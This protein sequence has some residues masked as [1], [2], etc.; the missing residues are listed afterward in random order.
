[1]HTHTHTH[2]HKHTH[3]YIRKCIHSYVRSEIHSCI[4][5]RLYIDAC[6]HICIYLHTHMHSIIHTQWIQTRC[7]L[8]YTIWHNNSSY[9]IDM[10]VCVCVCVSGSLMLR[11]HKNCISVHLNNFCPVNAFPNFF[12]EFLFLIYVFSHH[13]VSCVSANV[14]FFVCVYMCALIKLY[15]HQ[16]RKRA[17]GRKEWDEKE[18]F[19][20]D[21]ES[22][23]K[24][25]NTPS[26]KTA[27]RSQY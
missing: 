7:L 26:K 13:C 19:Q 12:C 9:S 24:G 4:H 1:M 22:R 14:H 21:T 16:C 20:P 27:H 2:T 5:T 15:C 3:K 10:C 25:C 18:I 23:R 8:Q 6:I 17:K 11:I